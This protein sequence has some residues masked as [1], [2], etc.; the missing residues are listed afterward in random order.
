MPSRLFARRVGAHRLDQLVTLSSKA[1]MSALDA[2]QRYVIAPL[3]D[4]N[5]FTARANGETSWR[6]A[7]RADRY[8]AA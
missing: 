5:T 6:E 3:L 7:R 8:A 1:Y 2:R 4:L